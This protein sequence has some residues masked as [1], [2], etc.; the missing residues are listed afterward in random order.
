MTTP[1]GLLCLQVLFINAHLSLCLCEYS[2]CLY[3]CFQKPQQRWAQLQ[4]LPVLLPW[5]WW[6]Q[7]AVTSPTR[8]KSCASV[9]SVSFYITVFQK[10]EV[11]GQCSPQSG[12]AALFQLHL[13]DTKPAFRWCN[14]IILSYCISRHMIHS[15]NR[16]KISGLG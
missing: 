2:V 4:G 11:S 6:V 13:K 1:V 16:T 15:Y 7:S 5:H 14:I 9:Y 3:V 8:R 12:T 10:R